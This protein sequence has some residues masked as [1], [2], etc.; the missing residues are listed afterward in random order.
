MCEREF[1]S[2]G[3]TLYRAVAGHPPEEA[4]LRKDEDHMPA[5]SQVAGKGGYR[6]GFLSAVDACLSVRELER[7]KSV[8][9]LRPLM[10]G[11]EPR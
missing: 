11:S 9:Q 5:A 10:L 2:L 7:P 6:P 4:T 1:Y 8:A 3:A